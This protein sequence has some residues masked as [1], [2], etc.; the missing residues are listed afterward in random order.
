MIKGTTPTHYFTL[1]FDTDILANARVTYAQNE[2]VI[3]TKE[4]NECKCDKNVIS[5]KLSQEETL[6]FNYPKPVQIQVSILTKGGDLLKSDI[7]T[8]S[9]KQ[10]LDKEVLV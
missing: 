9:I 7:L 5:C 6:K 10:C 3:L 4:L 2:I 1:P 8:V